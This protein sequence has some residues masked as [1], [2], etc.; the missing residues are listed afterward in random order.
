MVPLNPPILLRC[1]EG[2]EQCI[3]PRISN[4]RKD[5]VGIFV[6]WR[7]APGSGNLDSRVPLGE[8]IACFPGDALG[9][10]EK[11]DTRSR[12]PQ[13]SQQQGEIDSGQTR[14]HTDSLNPGSQDDAHPVCGGQ[15][16]GIED[17]LKRGV[18]PRHHDEFRVYCHDM[19]ELA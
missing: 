5:L 10:P 1:S 17:F 11:K 13:T 7:S 12:I 16:G 14:G 2:D 6:P 9:C 15:C 3:C 8:P 18:R 4:T 19:N